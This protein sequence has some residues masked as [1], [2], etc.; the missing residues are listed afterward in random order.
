MVAGLEQVKC[1]HG[2]GK[3]TACVMGTSPKGPVRGGT[4]DPIEECVCVLNVLTEQHG[5]Q[6]LTWGGCRAH[7][8]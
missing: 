5:S 6:R 7:P 1:L 4:A 2:S 3:L 8:Y